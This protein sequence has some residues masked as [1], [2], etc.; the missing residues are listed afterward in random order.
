M[1]AD[2]DNLFSPL[3]IRF[4]KFGLIGLLTTGLG[5]AIYY[6]FL[7]ILHINVFVAY[8][9]QFTIM[10]SFSYFLN[11]RFNYKIK[12]SLSKWLK[13]FNSYALSGFVGFILLAALKYSLPALDDFIIILML[14]PLKA[15]LTFVLVEIV[16]VRSKN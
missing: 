2:R 3:K 10:V 11:S 16:M 4:L 7:K 5:L 8:P 15:V 6:V 1:S 14:V 9:V 12:L 13:F